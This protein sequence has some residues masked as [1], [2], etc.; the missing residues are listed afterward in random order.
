MALPAQ[1]RPPARVRLLEGEPEPI[2]VAALTA[3]L[4]AQYWRR[5]TIKEG[6]KGPLVADVPRLR[7]IAV[8]GAC[9]GLRCGWSCDATP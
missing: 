4:P 9:T 2:T 7:V 3:Q 6:S 5:R 8:R 1:G